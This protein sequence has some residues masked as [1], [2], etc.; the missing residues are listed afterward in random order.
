MTT[1]KVGILVIQVLTFAALGAI[2]CAEGQ[3]RLGIA[4]LMLAGVQAIIYSGGV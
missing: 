4:Q 2:F 3:W 1:I